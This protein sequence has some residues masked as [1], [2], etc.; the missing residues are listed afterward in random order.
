MIHGY[1]Y[2]V[3]TVTFTLGLRT[4]ASCFIS[5]LLTKTLEF[6]L[7]P[8]QRRRTGSSSHFPQAPLTLKTLLIT[9][10]HTT[11]T[12]NYCQRAHSKAKTEVRMIAGERD[13]KTKT[14]HSE[15]LNWRLAHI[16]GTMLLNRLTLLNRLL[17]TVKPRHDT[18]WFLSRGRGNWELTVRHFI[19][20]VLLIKWP[21]LQHLKPVTVLPVLPV[22]P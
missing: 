2:N 1:L 8:C 15:E 17:L 22:A 21:L 20:I 9:S 10:Q 11:Y 5:G 7:A 12:E 13:S 18:T 19:Q 6:Q 4:Q 14:R 16:P 3:V